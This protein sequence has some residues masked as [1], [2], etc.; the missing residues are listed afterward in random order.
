MYFIAG[1]LYRIW[2]GGVLVMTSRS[3]KP[4]WICKKLQD[5]QKTNDIDVD[6]CKD[7]IDQSGNYV[8]C[9][10]CHKMKKDA[11]VQASGH[12]TTFL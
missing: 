1:Q 4:V 8:T 12:T 3:E 11:D 6:L 10:Q 5:D 9:E 2:G 7:A